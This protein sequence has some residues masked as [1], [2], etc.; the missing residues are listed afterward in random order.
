MHFWNTTLDSGIN[1]GVRLLIFGIFSSG[2]VLIKGGTFINLFIFFSFKYFFSTFF[3]FSCVLENQNICYFKRGLRLF[4]GLCLLF[5]PNFPGALFIQAATFIPDFEF[6]FG[7]KV[8]SKNL[9]N[10]IHFKKQCF[11]SSFVLT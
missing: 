3:F 4:K 10:P 8:R 1:V 7:K 5:L 11:S 9:V 2:Y 6:H